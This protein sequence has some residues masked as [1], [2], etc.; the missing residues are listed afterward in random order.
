M[1]LTEPSPTP[2][3]QSR[4]EPLA[5]WVETWNMRWLARRRGFWKEQFATGGCAAALIFF[6]LLT[7]MG[8]LSLLTMIQGKWR[9]RPRELI[10]PGFCML[11]LS[12]LMGVVS[13]MG[14]RYVQLHN[15][16]FTFEGGRRTPPSHHHFK[17]LKSIRC[18]RTMNGLLQLDFEDFAAG[19]VEAVT[20][21]VPAEHS[22]K[23]LDALEPFL[24][25]Q[26]SSEST[27]LP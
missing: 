24:E 1:Y 20:M 13:V 5:K 6:V 19:W 14:N 8:L 25:A 16:R 4:P 18:T 27:P 3:S 15:D 2:P 12:L 22:L 21:I 17:D 23:V 10:I 9:T 26:Y 7:T 11:G